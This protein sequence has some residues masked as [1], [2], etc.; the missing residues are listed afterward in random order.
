[1]A[2]MPGQGR[3]AGEEGRKELGGGGSEGLEEEEK[4]GVK[5]WRRS[6]WRK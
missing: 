3:E 2:G 6:R 5:N 4:E 1:M